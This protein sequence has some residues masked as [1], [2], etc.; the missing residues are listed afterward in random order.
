MRVTPKSLALILILFF[1]G[2]IFLCIGISSSSQHSMA[3]GSSCPSSNSAE[4]CQTPLDHLSYWS[5]IFSAIPLDFSSLITALVFA[6]AC[7]WL[8]C[9]GI[10]NPHT[11]FASWEQV[12]SPPPLFIPRNS[13]QEAFSNGIIHPKLY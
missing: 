3:M 1:I 12:L 5:S 10:W 7:L 9:R 2:G 11:L 8:V 6:C 13:L 4:G